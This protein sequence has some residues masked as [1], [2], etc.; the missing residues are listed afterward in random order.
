MDN[1][2]HWVRAERKAKKALETVVRMSAAGVVIDEVH[3]CV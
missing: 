3:C 1:D 2:G